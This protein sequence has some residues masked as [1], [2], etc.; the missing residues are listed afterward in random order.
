MREQEIQFAIEDARYEKKEKRTKK[1][2]CL[3]VELI[4]LGMLID[5]LE[6]KLLYENNSEWA[7]KVLNIRLVQLRKCYHSKLYQLRDHID[8]KNNY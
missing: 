2:N 6:R 1:L 5:K 8:D 4:N 3:K 7:E